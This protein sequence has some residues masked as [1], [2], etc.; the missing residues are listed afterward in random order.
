M[1]QKR[2]MDFKELADAFVEVA[3]PKPAGQVRRLGIPGTVDV[4]DLSPKVVWRQ[5]FFLLSFFL[6][7]VNWLKQ[8]TL[9]RVMCVTQSLQV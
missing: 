7:V 2:L 9:D 5:N 6:M 8:R 4:A 3:T 1:E